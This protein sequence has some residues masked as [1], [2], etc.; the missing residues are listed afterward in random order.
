MSQFF[1]YGPNGDVLTVDNIVVKKLTIAG[2]DGNSFPGIPALN[3][4]QITGRTLN[5]ADA[6]Q[7]I[8][9]DKGSGTIKR[10]YVDGQSVDS[11]FIRIRFDG[12]AACQ[13]GASTREVPVVNQD[14][15]L[16]LLLTRN[17]STAL[18]TDSPRPYFS[19]HAGCDTHSSPNICGYLELDMPYTKGYSIELRTLTD[20]CILNSLV[21]S[22]DLQTLVATDL[23]L[24]SRDFLW[25]PMQYP[26]EYPLMSI[27][28]NSGVYLKGMKMFCKTASPATPWQYG[29][30][31]M[32]TGGTP[33]QAQINS[34]HFVDAQQSV[35]SPF[36]PDT[37]VLFRSYS[38]PHMFGVGGNGI[39]GSTADG[40]YPVGIDAYNLPADL[41]MAGSF[42]P[43]EGGP[44]LVSVS[45]GAINAFVG[46][47]FFD[48]AVPRAKPNE[49]L[50]VTMSPTTSTRVDN[51]VGH[52]YYYA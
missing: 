18:S 40:V 21:V 50:T 52:L 45:G 5:T 44:L 14:M 20:G 35:L 31:R 22:R 24:H 36:A 32:Y 28:G 37:T 15:S 8:A 23:R 2:E 17:C 25:Q 7:V 51:V 13:F 16:P 39:D 30:V 29:E 19:K 10:I 43:D 41:N 1:S 9:A 34:S 33:L 12:A 11:C 46:L 27:K 38:I 4:Q 48:R 42:I 47:R 3:E 26:S 6:W 49:Y